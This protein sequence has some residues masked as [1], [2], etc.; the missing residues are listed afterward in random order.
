M[1]LAGSRPTKALNMPSL[2]VRHHIWDLRSDPGIGARR[3]SGTIFGIARHQFW[4]RQA[5]VLGSQ[6]YF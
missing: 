4:N 3:L 1:Q 6:A 2:I 5:P